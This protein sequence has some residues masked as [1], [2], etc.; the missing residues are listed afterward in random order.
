MGEPTYGLTPLPPDVAGVDGLGSAVTV[1]VVE[2]GGAVVVAV[3]ALFDELADA[4][5]VDVWLAQLASGVGVSFSIGR[6]G[7]A[8]GLVLACT[9]VLADA[10]RLALALA[11]AL[12]LPVGDAA[13]LPVVALPFGLALA[14]SVGL[15]VPVLSDGLAVLGDALTPGL[16]GALVVAAA[17]CVVVVTAGLAELGV[18]EGEADGHVTVEGAGL[19]SDA[20][21]STPLGP[22][23]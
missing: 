12:A 2:A 10:L 17:E 15:P 16:V 1:G 21:P 7:P 22:E 20:L 5:A 14:L 19:P 8:C 4:P 23:D 6:D 13:G 18:C 3:F 11:L 9:D